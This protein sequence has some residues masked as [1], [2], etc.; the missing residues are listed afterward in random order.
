MRKNEKK[1]LLITIIVGIIIIGGLILWTNSRKSK[2][3]SGNETNTNTE[4]FV[5]VLEDGS[6]LNKSEQFSKTKQLD[7]LE[8]RDI[9]F[10][11]IG[12]ITT[13]L[14]TVENKSG[15]AVEKRWIKVDVL[16][17]SGNTITTVR[18]IINAMNAG[19]TTQLNM[20]VTADV[21]NAYDFKVSNF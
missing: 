6:K 19:E 13:L 16:D 1:T 14:A 18:G 11:E 10:R 12:G 15:K 21:A 20:G 9:Q 7:G 5:E 4:E 17:K 3:T 8:I 2:P